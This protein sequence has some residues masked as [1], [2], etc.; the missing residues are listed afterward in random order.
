MPTIRQLQYFV[1]V[2]HAGSLRAAGARIG[3]SQPTLSA[4]LSSLEQMLGVTLFERSRSGMIA[5]PAARDLLGQAETILHEMTLL[6]EMARAGAEGPAGTHR[7]GVPPTLGP[8]FLPEVIATLHENYPALRLYVREDAPR[9]LERKLLDG[10]YDLILAPLPLSAAELTI[11]VLFNEP[12]VLTSAPD[13]PLA[14]KDLVVDAD[15]KGEKLLALE[16]RYRFFDQVQELA[17]RYEARLLREYEGTSL[18]TLRHMVG[19]GMGLG[20]LPALYVRSEIMPRADV[21]V[22]PF[23]KPPAF[24]TVALAWRPRSPHKRLYRDIAQLFRAICR[25]RLKDEVEVPP[26]A[27]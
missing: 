1:E 18:D 26:D 22:L 9:D 3:V 4:Q 5:T 8:Y 14:K 17:F 20:F 23:E 7:L 6:T 25:A 19:M 13:H 21:A 24:R 27:G 15:L 16:D 2:M 11:D 10:H 12:L